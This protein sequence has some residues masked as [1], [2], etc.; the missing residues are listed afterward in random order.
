MQYN[1]SEISCL[2][3][4]AC[5]A[6]IK[7]KT[8]DIDS[9]IGRIYLSD[10]RWNRDS[11]HPATEDI[12]FRFWGVKS[13]IAMTGIDINKMTDTCTRTCSNARQSMTCKW[14]R[15]GAE[16]SMMYPTFFYLLDHPWYL[17]G[18]WYHNCEIELIGSHSLSWLNR[19]PIRIWITLETLPNHFFKQTW[20]QMQMHES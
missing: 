11:T 10:V 7:R 9:A 4:R 12:S 17:L 16:R 8:V 5:S 2:Y 14:Q 19:D 20:L 18:K 15:C 1:P 13:I 3:H 6:R